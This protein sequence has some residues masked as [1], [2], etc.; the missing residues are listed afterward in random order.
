MFITTSSN[1][2][3]RISPFIIY[4]RRRICVGLL[5][6]LLTTASGVTV[7]AQS[8]KP[9]TPLEKSEKRPPDAL[10][11]LRDKLNE[12]KVRTEKL[13]EQVNAANAQKRR[14]KEE[15]ETYQKQIQK[16]REEIPEMRRWQGASFIL[17]DSRATDAVAIKVEGSSFSVLGKAV[18]EYV[19][20]RVAAAANAKVPRVATAKGRQLARLVASRVVPGEP[21]PPELDSEIR[22]N[23]WKTHSIFPV[24]INGRESHP[25]LRFVVLRTL[26]STKQQI[27]IVQRIDP[28]SLTY[29]PIGRTE[30]TIDRR[31]VELGSVRADYGKDILDAVDGDAT[32]LDFCIL[33][34]AD[35]LH[36][37]GHELGTMA[38]GV[39]VVLDG[40]SEGLEDKS[41]RTNEF[42]EL[43]KNNIFEAF[44][45]NIG[46]A[47]R[48]DISKEIKDPN[49]DLKQR[50]REAE[51]H[52][53]AKL[54]DFRIPVAESEHVDYLRSARQ[55]LKP[56]KIAGLLNVTHLVVAEFD[57]TVRDVPR[58]SVRLISAKDGN[59]LWAA[60]SDLTCP[61]QESGNSFFLKSGVLAMMGLDP[62]EP[63][64]KN[65]ELKGY[66]EPLKVAF[67]HKMTAGKLP[68]QQLVILEPAQNKL[69][70]AYRPMFDRVIQT[71]PRKV[72]T[73]QELPKGFSQ[74][75]AKATTDSNTNMSEQLARAIVWEFAAK[76]LT[77][78]G[79]VEEIL[80]DRQA[81]RLSIGREN[82]LKADSFVR[83]Y[84][85]KNATAA[86][87]GPSDFPL[88]MTLRIKTLD[89][90][91]S[92]AVP[93]RTGLDGYWEEDGLW[94]QIGDIVFNP[95]EKPRKVAIF[96]PENKS[97]DLSELDRRKIGDNFVKK[98]QDV[99][100][101]TD[102]VAKKVQ[103]KL[104]DGFV[105]LNSVAYES[106]GIFV[107]KKLDVARTCEAAHANGAT[108][109]I[110]GYIQ[111]AK[112]GT[113]VKYDVKL[114]M[115]EL[116]KN[117]EGKWGLGRDIHSIPIGKLGLQT[118]D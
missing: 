95:Y 9:N 27:G 28:T 89:D 51:D 110:G 85:P 11:P 66:E 82:E 118:W 6:G 43:N 39:H 12:Q 32:Y 84:R 79:R 114:I 35:K 117:K 98:W 108:H 25:E 109:A 42:V 87:D 107:N 80:E 48:K 40:M 23:I 71:V 53:Y 90:S 4:Y 41:G 70:L 56:E 7:F 68:S 54:S 52:L 60:N 33:S 73:V 105:K 55:S 19:A 116:A 64:S 18:G 13:R 59:A 20:G 97:N 106:E 8:P 86:D 44:G 96:P 99:V 100:Q 91:S 102:E 10:D 65:V 111:P 78:A 113:S 61:K 30:K 17:G 1:I 24:P 94:P 21:L 77:P 83:V 72:V 115:Y 69:E 62:K 45:L 29:L 67:A 2:C 92:V 57:R 38:V 49:V 5:T 104:R 74:Y 81:Y 37:I 36:S 76:G 34:I 101:N 16:L 58:L 88:P 3:H 93:V 63:A 15:L 75:L 31:E 47:F 50:A 22:S 14:A 46:I 26:S 112:A 103:T